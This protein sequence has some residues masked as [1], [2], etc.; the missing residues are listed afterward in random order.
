MNEKISSILEEVILTSNNEIDI[1]TNQA[2]NKIN[3]A[4]D[5]FRYN[6]IIAVFHEIYTFFNKLAK[7]NMHYLNLKDNY[8]KILI[9]MM[10]VIPH[11]IN[12]CLEKINEKNQIVW[13]EI[14]KKFIQEDTVNIVIQVNGKKR[15]IISVAKNL[16]EKIILK[17]I[18]QEKLTEKYT[19]NKEIIRTIYIKDKIINIIIG[20]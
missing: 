8:K 2:I 9:I 4:L 5:K 20:K 1:F 17:K 15:S 6:V 13:P 19:K 16:D 12:E 14:E 3:F 18:E 10:P 7:K 11:L